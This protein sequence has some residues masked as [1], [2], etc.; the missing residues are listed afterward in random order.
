MKEAE[1]QRQAKLE[2]L[3][4]LEQERAYQQLLKKK[5]SRHKE[6][7]KA[8]AEAATPT[9]NTVP[10][11]STSCKVAATRSEKTHHSV[12]AVITTNG[13]HRP[14]TPGV[15]TSC[16]PSSCR[17]SVK[18]SCQLV[19]SAESKPL[20]S[21]DCTGFPCVTSQQ[22]VKPRRQPQQGDRTK[23]VANKLQLKPGGSSSGCNNNIENGSPKRTPS[24]KLK[25]SGDTSDVLAQNRW[26]EQTSEA[27]LTIGRPQLCGQTKVTRQ[28]C[29]AVSSAHRTVSNGPVAS[30]SCTAANCS[31][32]TAQNC[33]TGNR[34]RLEN[35]TNH[36]VTTKE[37]TACLHHFMQQHHTGFINTASAAP[38]K[39]CHN[40]TDVPTLHAAASTISVGR[41]K[42]H[43]LHQTSEQG[44]HPSPQ[45]PAPSVAPRSG[46]PT[47]SHVDQQQENGLCG[48]SSLTNHVSSMSRSSPGQATF[49]SLA[50]KLDKKPLPTTQRQQQS[51]TANASRSKC[52][53]D[54]SPRSNDQVSVAG[55]LTRHLG[56]NQCQ[57]LQFTCFINFN[58]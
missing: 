1:E 19:A 32:R 16:A 3:R 26:N 53:L 22:P 42:A 25:K 7:Q 37:Q 46:H 36:H 24:L 23:K 2:Q 5:H 47:N 17:A 39:T 31:S 48:Q 28:N 29:V 49:E 13:Q 27:A 14:S 33:D 12:G 8:A 18:K 45:L 41:K 10:N 44:S 38:L 43:K 21:N 56:T 4:V 40:S 20:R 52:D 50:W 6:Q 34:G 51:L 58:N 9:G 11:S 30:K 15:T 55:H 54:R 57:Q 35:K